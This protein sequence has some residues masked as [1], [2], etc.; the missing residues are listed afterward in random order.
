MLDLN[1]VCCSPYSL[2]ILD[3]FVRAKAASLC[4]APTITICRDLPDA[5]IKKTSAIH[6]SLTRVHPPNR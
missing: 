3:S 5:V 6:R 1:L 4:S 2:I